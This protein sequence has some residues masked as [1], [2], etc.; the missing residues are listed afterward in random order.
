MKDKITTNQVAYASAVIIMSTGLLIKSLYL[1]V[2]NDSWIAVTAGLFIGLLLTRIYA[3]LARKYPDCTLIEINEQVYGRILGKTLSALYVF[4]FFTIACLNTNILGNFVKSY[5]M[6]NTPTPIIL[7]LFVA[8]CVFAVRKGQVNIMR[9]STLFAVVTIV[10]IVGNGLL[11]YNIFKPVNLQPVL[12]LPIKNYLIGTHGI[13]M[14]PICD[15]LVFIMF[16]PD[17]QKPKEFGKALARG[18]TIGSI[19]LIL[20]VLRDIMVLGG[21]IRLFTSPSY[22][23]IRLI[24]VG[25]ILTR[26]DVIFI[27]T[28][29]SLIFYKVSVFLYATVSGFRR[30]MEFDSHR[31][32]IYIFGALLVIYSLSIFESESAH[33]Q[34][35]SNGA[36]SMFQTVFLVL[37]PIITL[38]VSAFR[39]KAKKMD[40]EYSVDIFDS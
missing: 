14:I 15:P 13:S 30:L 17:M 19:V 22:S 18:I 40:S 32:L 12:A 6:Q 8:L 25:D 2:K 9:Y 7:V 27:S 26:M 5:V 16:L 11:M 37:L 21:A 1:Y 35:R 23:S 4:F 39:G 24:D 20:I 3:A 34:W 29:I 38:I 33:A 28:F 36:A 31:F 10:I